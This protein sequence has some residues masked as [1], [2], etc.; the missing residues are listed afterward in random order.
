MSPKSPLI[1]TAL[2]SVVVAVAFAHPRQALAINPC[3]TD[4][5]QCVYVNSNLDNDVRD[6]VI[7]LREALLLANGT[8]TLADLTIAELGQV[9]I[10]MPPGWGPEEDYT[11]GNTPLT[12][13]GFGGPG[14]IGKTSVHF[15]STVF[16]QGCPSS[17][18]L[19][20]PA[21][22]PSVVGASAVGATDVWAALP[23]L[24]PDSDSVD[25]DWQVQ[26]GEPSGATSSVSVN[27]DGSRLSMGAT[28][29][30]VAAPGVT[31]QGVALRRFRGIAVSLTCSAAAESTM[32]VEFAS[33]GTDIAMTDCWSQNP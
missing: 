33:N 30:A 7:T 18:I 3:S 5:D 11:E 21:A 27:I 10:T 16:C 31:L 4:F 20:D 25:G 23:V 6:D 2:A 13:P 9:V 17:T 15:D 19:L 24:A 28:G 8:L 29:F 1:L 22:A 26:I 32:D 14:G 12:P